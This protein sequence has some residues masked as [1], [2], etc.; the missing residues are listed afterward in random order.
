MAAIFSI[1][2]I[3]TVATWTGSASLWR[4][5]VSK[6]QSR[7]KAHCCT[8]PINNFRKQ[9]EIKKQERNCHHV[10]ALL[11]C[12]TPSHDCCIWS[13]T[14]AK[15]FLLALHFDLRNL[16]TL[17]QGAIGSRPSGLCF[18][19]LWFAQCSSARNDTFSPIASSSKAP[20]NI[21]QISKLLLFFLVRSHCLFIFLPSTH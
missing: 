3:D 20:P 21:I 18:V 5:N 13:P 11:R 10:I 15:S 14:C 19:Y 7:R 6:L 4:P 2:T 9:E 1:C 16:P 12:P 17:V 8:V